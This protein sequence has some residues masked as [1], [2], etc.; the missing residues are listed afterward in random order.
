MGVE[1]KPCGVERDLDEEK[2]S[3]SHKLGS[4]LK[5]RSI[6][7]VNLQ[8]RRPLRGGVRKATWW[9]TLQTWLEQRNGRPLLPGPNYTK[10][11]PHLRKNRTTKG[12]AN[13]GAIKGC[14][15]LQKIKRT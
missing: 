5:V 1:R 15:A 6:I 7:A 4:S 12:G 11:T 14:K 8:K 2:T 10:R 3:E 13:E 9:G